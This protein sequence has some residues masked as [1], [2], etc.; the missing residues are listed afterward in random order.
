MNATA[1]ES[2]KNLG[3]PEIKVTLRFGVD[4]NS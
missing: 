4:V 2:G 1:L 3:V